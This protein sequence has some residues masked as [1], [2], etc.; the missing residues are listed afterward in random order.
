MPKPNYL[1]YILFTIAI[2][3]QFSCSHE[4]NYPQELVM[5]D[6][7]YMKGN[8]QL[9]DALLEASK[10]SINWEDG[11][12]ANYYNLITLEQAFLYDKLSGVHFSLADSLLRFNKEEEATSEKHA[13]SLLFIGYIYLK[14]KDYP[15][16][17][18]YLLEARDI[19]L[20]KDVRLYYIT[21]RIIGDLYFEQRMFDDCIPYYQSYN[22][23]AI[24]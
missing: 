16:S 10:K 6:S 23:L 12:E 22:E 2:S 11:K 5:A 20:K 17:I 19:A 7:A 14:N 3:L 13:K 21:N 24:C 18:K 1:L 4:K 9:A 15:S 8:Y